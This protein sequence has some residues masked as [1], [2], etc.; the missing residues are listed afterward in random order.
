MKL[1]ILDGCKVTAG[2]HVIGNTRSLCMKQIRVQSWVMVP[3]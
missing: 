1:T 3:S 2:G